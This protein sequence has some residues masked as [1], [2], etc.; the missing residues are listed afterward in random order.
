MLVPAS[1]ASPFPCSLLQP[2]L[3]RWIYAGEGDVGAD[4]FD[5]EQGGGG[6]KARRQRCW[7]KVADLWRDGPS[8]THTT[9]PSLPSAHGSVPTRPLQAPP[10]A[11][12]SWSSSVMAELARKRARR[13]PEVDAE[14]RHSSSL[15]P[16]SR[17]MVVDL[18]VETMS[19]GGSGCASPP[20]LPHLILRR[21]GG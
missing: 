19:G 3:S 14:Q 20:S 16:D 17:S 6:S 1:S 8:P 4:S 10:T 18:G 5:T 11:T 15:G 21:R 12:T 13:R 9:R 2:C 7:S